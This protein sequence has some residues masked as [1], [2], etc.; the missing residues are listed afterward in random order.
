M[1]T[2][3]LLVAFFVCGRFYGARWADDGREGERT[4]ERLK[5][6]KDGARMEKKRGKSG[7]RENKS[8]LLGLFWVPVG[9]LAGCSCMM[10]RAGRLK[11]A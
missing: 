4:G 3:L 11:G 2:E 7:R 8:G 1:A 10:L 5:R 9:A 6:G